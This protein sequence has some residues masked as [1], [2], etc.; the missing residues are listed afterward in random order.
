MA[1]A[2]LTNAE[3][4][5]FSAKRGSG[6]WIIVVDPPTRERLYPLYAIDNTRINKIVTDK[7]RVLAVAIKEAVKDE[8]ER[9]KR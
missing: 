6:E 1:K 8:L 4:M 2:K 7:Y 5:M 9:L 3:L